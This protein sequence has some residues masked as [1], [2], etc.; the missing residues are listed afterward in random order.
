LFSIAG[1]SFF[2]LYDILIAKDFNPNERTGYVFSRNNIKL[3]LPEQLRL[4]I[5]SFYLQKSRKQ[6]SLNQLFSKKEVILKPANQHFVHQCNLCLTVYDENIGEETTGIPPGT[7]F[8]TLPASYCCPTC[9]S[10]KKNFVKINA[11]EL[12]GI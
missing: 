8:E 7:K 11:E 1:V 6:T 10:S 4:A 3:F 12:A 2:N 5:V 9:D